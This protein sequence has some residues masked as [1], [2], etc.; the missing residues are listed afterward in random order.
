MK[1]IRHYML[2]RPLSLVL[3]ATLI[4]QIAYP[5]VSYALTSGPST[6]EVQS[7]EPVGTTQLVDPFSG[8]FNYNIPLMDVGGYPINL[9]YHAGISM[10]QEASWVGLGW[11]INPGVINRDLRGIPDD[12]DGDEIK[13]Q[14]NRKPNINTSLTIGSPLSNSEIFGYTLKPITKNS[15]IGITYNNYKGVGFE[16]GR[17]LIHQSSS[18]GISLDYSHAVKSVT[19]DVL[20]DENG[21][22][23]RDKV[24]KKTNV[25]IGYNSRTGLK[26]IGIPRTHNKR[27]ASPVIHSF[28]LRNY[29]PVSNP[30]ISSVTANVSLKTGPEA[31]GFFSGQKLQ[32]GF[33]DYYI[34][35]N[36]KV[37]SRKSYGYLNAEKATT[38]AVM[39]KTNSNVN[40]NKFSKYI[41]HSVHTYDFL[42]VSGQGIGGQFRP[43]R[44]QVGSIADHSYKTDNKF[45]RDGFGFN[46]GLEFG[47]GNAVKVGFDIQ[48]S[49][50]LHSSGKWKKCKSCNNKTLDNLTFKDNH[51]NLKENFYFKNLG[52]FTVSDADYY[53]KIKSEQTVKVSLKQLEILPSVSPS[54]VWDWI[55]GNLPSNSDDENIMLDNV[56]K[57]EKREKRNDMIQ[58]LSQKERTTYGIE[59]NIYNYSGTKTAVSDVY[60]KDHHMS[61]ITTL[62]GDGSR[63]VYGIPAYG[64]QKDAS[65]AIGG[66]A[67][68]YACSNKGLVEY[69]ADDGTIDNKKGIDNFYQSTETPDHAYAYHLTCILSADYADLTGNGP[70]PDDFGTYTKFNYERLANPFKWRIP[71]TAASIDRGMLSNPRD[72]RASYLYGEKE[73]WYVKSIETKTHVAI[74][75]M[76][77]REDGLGASAEQQLTI[78][79]SYK[80]SVML[81]KLDNIKLYTRE[82]I[83]NA[84]NVTILS[85]EIPVKTVNFEYSYDLCKNVPNNTNAVL[86]GDHPLLPY[87]GSAYNHKVNAFKGKLTLNKVYFTYGNSNKGS[88]NPYLFEYAENIDYKF[89]SSDRWNVYTDQNYNFRSTACDNNA[90]LQEFPYTEQGNKT[91]AD[92]NAS[93]WSLS[94]IYLPS[95]GK[96]DID[97]ES[98]DYGFVQ[99]KSAMQMTN[100]LGFANTSGI[101]STS[102]INGNFNSAGTDDQAYLFFDMDDNF[103]MADYMDDD[104]KNIYFK[105]YVN[106][107]DNKKEYVNGYSGYDNYGTTTVG[108]NK[109]GWIKVGLRADIPFSSKLH[110]PIKIQAFDFIRLEMPWLL[111]GGEDLINAGVTNKNVI[112]GTM[113]SAISDFGTLVK[114][115]Y[116]YMDGRFCETFLPNYCK[117]RLKNPA[118]IKFGGG[119]RVKSIIINDNWNALSTEESNSYGQVFDYT[120]VENSKVVSSGVASYEPLVGGDEIPQRQP[121]Y[122]KI[123]VPL[124]TNYTLYDDLPVCEDQYPG[125]MVGYSK[126]AVRDL[127]PSDLGISN[128]TTA[129]HGTGKTEYE[130]YT[131]RD[132]PTRSAATKLDRY[133]SNSLLLDFIGVNINKAIA[134]QGF[135]VELS[136]MHGKPKSISILNEDGTLISKTT[137]TYKGEEN[138][139]QIKLDNTIQILN[140]DGTVTNSLAGVDIETVVEPLESEDI[141]IAAGV[142]TNLDGFIMG[143]IPAIVPSIVPTWQ[144][145]HEQVKTV[146]VTKIIQKY[147]VLEKITVMKNGSTLETKNLAWDAETGE[148]LLTATETQYGDYDYGLSIPAHFAYEGM[149]A[150]YKNIYANFSATVS[151]GLITIPE[152]GILSP[153]DELSVLKSDGTFDVMAWVMDVNNTTLQASLIDKDGA[154]YANGT[155]SFKVIRSGRRNMQSTPVGNILMIT[156]PI[157]GGRFDSYA[158]ANNNSIIS[159]S[160][161][162]YNDKKALYPFYDFGNI[163]K[164]EGAIA[165]TGMPKIFISTIVE[166]PTQYTDDLSTYGYAYAS[167]SGVSG[168]VNRHLPCKLPSGCS[169]NYVNPFALGLMGAYFPYR[170]LRY[171]DKDYPERTTSVNL[172]VPSPNFNQTKAR[173]DGLLDNFEPFWTLSPTA[174]W[175][176]KSIDENNDE[177][178]DK[179]TW[180]SLSQIVDQ[181][182]NEIQTL[183]PLQI[184]TSAQYGYSKKFPVAVAE[185]AAHSEIVFDGFEEY[186]TDQL[187]TCPSLFPFTYL[188]SAGFNT[189]NNTNWHWMMWPNFT[190]GRANI[191]TTES[192]TGKNALVLS[193]DFVE[194][195]FALHDQPSSYTAAT[196]PKSQFF[197]DRSN[198]IQ[199]FYPNNDQLSGS[200]P[201][202]LSYW[203]KYNPE[204]VNPIFQ[205]QRYD[206]VNWVNIPTEEL[207]EQILWIDG[208]A[209][210]T[211][212]ITVPFIAKNQ[213]MRLRIYKAIPDASVSY[214]PKY[215]KSPTMAELDAADAK[216]VLDDIRI[217]P[218]QANMKCFV[219]D[220][221]TYRLMAELDA[222]HYATFYEYDDQGMMV[223]TKKETVR[224]IKTIQESRQNTRKR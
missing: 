215:K 28:A 198:T 95:G 183:N 53:N 119:H 184:H 34:R 191:T 12:F 129:K 68:P 82:Q 193:H 120:T 211:F 109:L 107:K 137:Y 206:G 19:Q 158:G 179:W 185:N 144:Y 73:I 49:I 27:D 32:L 102:E 224:G 175:G 124:A 104:N 153:G 151:G 154:K 141:Y 214:R 76:S 21:K 15:E 207:E 196:S 180:T 39:D 44:T 58:Y 212:E 100:I 98:D 216:V 67:D 222:N 161:V 209:K 83:D 33:S 194:I 72:D 152:S 80:G 174:Y 8:D 84:N 155:F 4:F 16:W 74:F 200:S 92:Q 140:K 167:M 31:T 128:V 60:R 208:W 181:N 17:G 176:H 13:Y 86:A 135:S 5:T 166:N 10:E 162:E 110:N 133:M 90:S 29:T 1:T 106:L 157:T 189:Y 186:T 149:D 163:R 150:T 88:L 146:S 65:F 203:G 75:N 136:D 178:T 126:I 115:V 14:F 138:G 172:S 116:K 148:V 188:A 38:E 147:A 143:I 118:G 169:V 111:H 7:F 177:L 221:K 45:S 69:A 197:L 168:P 114:G 160:A 77:N 63:Y 94:S 79:G 66:A 59:K 121:V 93:M 85:G 218:K 71:H 139:R 123:K 125:A 145:E 52:E 165:E 101:S 142:Q 6:P 2:S 210:K 223:R 46:G 213:P 89:K 220:N 192:H 103:N 22:S 182:G 171:Y 113:F 91:K 24:E 51:E 23:L 40:F 57:R 202:L 11:N 48:P 26:E 105:F 3:C 108:G 159:A 9:H 112:A 61:E 37:F 87:L 195:P 50:S 18:G 201:Y 134:S 20:V 217:M 173:T 97:L 41:G 164:C 122:R 54:Y 205:L 43:F 47:A 55:Q 117:I 170:T 199:G 64:K 99:D 35:Q 36:D 130:F 127:R 81:R 56:V 190:P 70:T 78:G 62:G 132:C 30:H 96:M 25:S 156:N 131:L 42:S 204:Y 187:Y 219:Y